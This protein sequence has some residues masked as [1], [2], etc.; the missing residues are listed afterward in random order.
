MWATLSH[1]K[2]YFV[3]WDWFYIG[4][5]L[6]DTQPNQIL[7]KY[8]IIITHTAVKAT[9]LFSQACTRRTD[10][11]LPDL[12]RTDQWLWSTW[13]RAYRSLIMIYLTYIVQISDPWSTWPRAYR[14][15]IMI[16]LTYIV[17]ISDHDLP[18][19]LIERTD[20]WSWSTWPTVVDPYGSVGWDI[21]V[22]HA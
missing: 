11:D 19:L 17:Q 14:P 15:L 22:D 8:P 6:Q 12:D 18:D 21:R 16:H 3:G 4:N 10:H 9:P 7:R 2:Y 13:P 20:H 5:R 1:S